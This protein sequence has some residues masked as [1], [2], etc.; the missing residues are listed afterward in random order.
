M[1]AEL[2]Y[3]GLAPIP[4]LINVDG[5]TPSTSRTSCALR[6]EC[7]NLAAVVAMSPAFIVTLR[8]PAHVIELAN[9]K[10]YQLIGRRDII[11]KTVIEAA[12]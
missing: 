1:T 4:T 9:E 3:F 11:G 5:P 10:Y 7:A 6:A 12:A 2:S 8:G